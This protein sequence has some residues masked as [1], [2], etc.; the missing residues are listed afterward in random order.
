MSIPLF[1]RCRNI[2]LHKV[3]LFSRKKW[4]QNVSPRGKMLP[5]LIT[6]TSTNPS[7]S[8]DVIEEKNSWTSSLLGTFQLR[9]TEP[10]KRNQK[11]GM[12]RN[13]SKTSR[14]TLK[15]FELERLEAKLQSD[16]RV[17]MTLRKCNETKEKLKVCLD[18]ASLGFS[19]F[20]TL[21]LDFL[22]FYGTEFKVN[23]QLFGADMQRVFFHS[24]LFV[25]PETLYLFE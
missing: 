10:L 24:F 8:Y 22:P 4:D 7:S 11:V 13:F 18:P 20:Q 17:A 9:I 25:T 1:S 6:L 21:S 3:G 5:H 23:L 14:K 15:A 12:F 16:Q 2:Q 19:N